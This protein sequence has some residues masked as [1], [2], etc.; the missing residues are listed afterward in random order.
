M[1][2]GAHHK[3]LMCVV[4]RIYIYTRTI[5]KSFEVGKLLNQVCFV[6]F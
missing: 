5:G 2:L 3:A 1:K 4:Q 6:A